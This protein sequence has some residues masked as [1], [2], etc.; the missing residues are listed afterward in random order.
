MIGMRMLEVPNFNQLWFLFA[1]K[2][3]IGTFSCEASILLWFFLGGG[4]C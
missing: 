3:T 4:V 1:I 2:S